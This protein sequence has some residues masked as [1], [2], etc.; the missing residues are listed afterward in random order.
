MRWL[1]AGAGGL[2]LAVMTGCPFDY[3]KDGRADKEVHKTEVELV[4]KRCS[5][6]DREQFCGGDKKDSQE[7][8]DKCGG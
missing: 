7:C 2:L 4:V 8:H 1:K 5:E 6:K 3:G